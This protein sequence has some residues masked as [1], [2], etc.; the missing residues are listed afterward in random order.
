LVG[1]PM[2]APTDIAVKRYIAFQLKSILKLER[3]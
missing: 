3:L 1:T 2:V